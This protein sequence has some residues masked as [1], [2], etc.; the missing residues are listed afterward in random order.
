MGEL[1][2][3]RLMVSGRLTRGRL[4]RAARAFGWAGQGGGGV[5]C[6]KLSNDALQT[7]LR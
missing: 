7:Q 6:S 5:G 2:M 4:A 1:A 3:C